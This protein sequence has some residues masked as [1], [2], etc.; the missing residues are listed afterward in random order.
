MPNVFN[1]CCLFHNLIFGRNEVDVE[2]I[3]QVIQLETRIQNDALIGLN[4]G[5]D[6]IYSPSKQLSKK[7]HNLDIYI[8][9]KCN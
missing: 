7:R 5:E 1:M 9:A 8:G 2:E 6:N 4:H 3:M